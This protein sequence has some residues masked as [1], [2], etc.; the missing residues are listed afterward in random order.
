MKSST[1][2]KNFDPNLFIETRRDTRPSRSHPRCPT[3]NQDR[4]DRLLL[5]LNIF[6]AICIQTPLI[7]LSKF[8]QSLQL[9]VFDFYALFG[10]FPYFFWEMSHGLYKLLDSSKF[11]FQSTSFVH[12]NFFFFFKE[13]LW[14]SCLQFY[15]SH[16]WIL[17]YRLGLL[18]LFEQVYFTT[19]W[20]S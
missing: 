19:D 1:L 8:Q 7:T 3:I 16:L 15:L 20:E 9:L 18:V 2:S 17:I 11:T 12:K 13:C 10:L 4:A 14:I 5:T 6:G